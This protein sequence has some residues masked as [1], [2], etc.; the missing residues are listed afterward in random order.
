[1]VLAAHVPVML[2]EALVCAAAVVLI[3]K[4]KPELL[5]IVPGPSVETAHA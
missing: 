1:M 4:V 5:G 3:R 2:V